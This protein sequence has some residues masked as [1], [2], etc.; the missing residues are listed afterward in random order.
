MTA[1]TTPASKEFTHILELIEAAV[2]AR[3]DLVQIREKNL[4]AR[5]LFELA[6]LGAEIVRGSDTRLLVN[7]R[8]DIASSSGAHGVHLTTNSLEPAVVRQAFGADL[9]IGVSTHSLSEAIAARDGG[10]DFVV[11][12]PVFQTV[13]KQ[14]YGEPVGLETLRN[15]ASTLKGF[16]VLALG[17]V[18]TDNIRDCFRA[19]ADGVAA[20]RLLSD[21]AKLGDIKALVDGLF[22][23]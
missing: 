1:Q 23:H 12:G 18:A 11:F 13:S 7:D 2:A 6:T 21:P 4:S 15:A 16:P 19:G 3:I 8:A 22:D 5:V 17:G 20:I 9:L 10:A 14:S